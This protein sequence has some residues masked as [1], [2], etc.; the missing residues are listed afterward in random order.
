M[1]GLISSSF[2]VS[3]MRVAPDIVLS[4]Q[5]CQATLGKGQW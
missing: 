4:P 1:F 2:T 5:I 3:S